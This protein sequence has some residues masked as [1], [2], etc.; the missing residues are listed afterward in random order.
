M[1]RQVN[2]IPMKATPE[3]ERGLMPSGLNCSH[4]RQ[5]FGARRPLIGPVHSRQQQ[6]DQGLPVLAGRVVIA[7]MD[8]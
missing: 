7:A 4:P 1:A 6:R 3:R 2:G 5:L 8:D